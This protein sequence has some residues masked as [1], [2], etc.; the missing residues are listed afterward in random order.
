ML[1]RREFTALLGGVIAPWPLAARAQQPAM[2]VTGFLSS[3]SSDE[4]T[5]VMPE[6]HHGLN[7]TGYVEGRNI[8]I[9]YRW[10]EGHYERL[11]GMSADSRG[12]GHSSR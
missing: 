8:A 11:P 4:L 5:F 3:L 6:F 2:A 9:E 12:V 10:A 1:R 7:E